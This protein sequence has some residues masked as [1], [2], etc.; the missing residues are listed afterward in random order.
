MQRL[1]ASFI[2]HSVTPL[3]EQLQFGLELCKRFRMDAKPSNTAMGRVERVTEELD[4]PH[5]ARNG[6]FAIDF[7]V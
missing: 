5:T 2:T 1:L 4:I 7:E 6:L 3:G